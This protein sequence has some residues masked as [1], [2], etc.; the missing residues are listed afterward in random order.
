MARCKMITSRLT[1]SAWLAALL[2]PVCALTPVSAA[3]QAVSIPPALSDLHAGQRSAPASVA[4]P[5]Q[6][7]NLPAPS[8]SPPDKTTPA[9]PSEAINPLWV[10]PLA[11]LSPTRQRPI[12][13]PSR[14]PPV[15]V[16]PPAPVRVATPPPSRG[17]PKKPPFV[18]LGV[19]A[20]DNEH[21]ALLL[22]ETAKV[23]VRLRMGQSRSGW[24]LRSVNGHEATLE[25]YQQTATISF[26]T[27]PIGE[28]SNP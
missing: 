1:I 24:T 28:I 4:A 18:L 3:A 8:A 14:R 26:P 9:P 23:V 17:E 6:H 11:S 19:I 16:L 20:G 7:G 2:G 15:A 5:L 21:I 25:G 22:D 27:R 12:F 10:T 13:S